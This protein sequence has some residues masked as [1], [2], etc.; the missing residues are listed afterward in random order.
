VCSGGTSALTA[1]GALS[2]SWNGV[3]GGPSLFVYPLT[4]TIYTLTGSISN[5]CASS[6]TLYARLDIAHT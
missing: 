5:G 2:Y 4:T 6:G 1:F 3:P